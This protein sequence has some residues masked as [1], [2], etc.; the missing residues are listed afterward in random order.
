MKEK[1]L[2]KMREW[3]YKEA[4]DFFMK[5]E[6]AT[7]PEAVTYIYK[8]AK[9]CQVQDIRNGSGIPQEIFQ[10]NCFVL[11]DG[12]SCSG[13][14]TISNELKRRFPDTVEIVDIDILCLDWIKSKT[15]ACQSS[16]DKLKILYNFENLTDR[17]IKDNLE[18]IVKEKS[19]NNKTVILLG[20]FID[21]VFR[22]FVGTIF[23]KYFSKTVFLTLH[24]SWDELNKNL[25][26]RDKM[27]NEESKTNSTLQKIN[28]KQQFDFLEKVI[29]ENPHYL[30][31]GADCSFVINHGT[32]LY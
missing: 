5:H 9:K 31:V 12:E 26:K 27:F 19:K 8:I 18:D 15:E 14:T 32:K 17:F 10:G 2:K 25:E 3:T 20:C 4:Y 1:D 6:M 28:T 23:G 22:A 30:G 29:N 7:S 24:E 13:K 21:L 11:L 16:L